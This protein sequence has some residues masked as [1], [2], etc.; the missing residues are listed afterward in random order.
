MGKGSRQRPTDHNRYSDNYDMIFGSESEDTT[1]PFTCPYC[2]G[3]DEGDVYEDQVT[4]REP[5]GDRIVDRISYFYVCA[6]CDSHEV[7][8]TEHFPYG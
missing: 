4:D 7:E 1:H 8:R 2:G 5:Y 6:N 3:L